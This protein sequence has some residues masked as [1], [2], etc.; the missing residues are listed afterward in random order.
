MAHWILKAAVQR[1]I[2]LLPRS[3]SWNY[4]LQK[5]VTRSIELDEGRLRTYL[6]LYARRHI[7][8]WFFS[9][10]KSDF[11]VMELGTGWYPVIPIAF[12]LCGASKIW[13]IDK[14]PLLRPANVRRAVQLF[15]DLAQRQELMALLPRVQADRL[16]ALLSLNNNGHVVPYSEM[17]ARLNI[18]VLVLDAR[19]T[20][21]EQG[22]VDFF[23]SNAVLSEIPEHILLAIFAE[24]RRVASS[25]ATMSHY[26]SLVDPYVSFDDA[27]TPFHFLQYADRTWRLLNNS[28]HYHNRLRIPDYRRIHGSAGFRI[29]LEDNERGSPEDLEKVRLA[30][31]FQRYSR[32][33]LL[34]LR[35]WMLLAPQN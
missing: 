6:Q 14:Q 5:Y 35:S 12:Y 18:H 19:R 11:T 13:T 27:V 21:L 20:G 2:A 8:N 33:E 23:F 25:E 31:E 34:V 28:L 7:E 29:L 4:L 26:V 24:F 10:L 30:K 15:V 3:Q 17:L 22:S 1:S 16:A 32:D 9:H